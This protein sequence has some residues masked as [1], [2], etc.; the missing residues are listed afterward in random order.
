MAESAYYSD[1]KEAI[2]RF[3]GTLLNRRRMKL[4]DDLDISGSPLLSSSNS[5][6]CSYF[7]NSSDPLTEMRTSTPKLALGVSKK[8]SN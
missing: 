3:D 4:V 8:L 5:R 7:R 2:A 6:F 1:L